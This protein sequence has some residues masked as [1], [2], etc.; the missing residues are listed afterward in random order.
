MVRRRLTLE[1]PDGTEVLRFE[2][3]EDVSRLDDWIHD[4]YLEDDLSFSAEA[5]CAVIPFAQESGWGER[6]S[7]MADP[8]LVKTTLLARHFEVPLTR[9]YVVV[10]QATALDADIDWGNPSRP[11]ESDRWVSE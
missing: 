10:R 8:M 11:A 7:D 3:P 2:R 4:G 1:A 5:A 9:C 6:H